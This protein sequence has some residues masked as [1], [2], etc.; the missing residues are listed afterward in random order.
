VAILRQL[1]PPPRHMQSLLRPNQTSRDMGNLQV[2]PGIYP[3]NPALIVRTAGG[4]T[5]DGA[6]GAPSPVFAL[7]GRATIP[8][9]ANVRNTTFPHSRGSLAGHR[10]PSIQRWLNLGRLAPLKPLQPLQ[11]LPARHLVMWRFLPSRARTR[12]ICAEGR[13]AKGCDRVKN[14]FASRDGPACLTEGNEGSARHGNGVHHGRFRSPIAA[15]RAIYSNRSASPGSP[16]KSGPMPGR[17]EWFC[18]H[19]PGRTEQALRRSPP[20]PSIHWCSSKSWAQA[21][22]GVA[23]W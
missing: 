23:V 6:L 18:C 4:R 15:F 13:A 2:L 19:R 17:G 14:S 5:R 1:G 16:Y 10:C 8:G 22:S 20:K 11:A 21:F 12:L 3:D 9:V 7:K